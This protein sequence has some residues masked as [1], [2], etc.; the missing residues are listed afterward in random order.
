MN[1]LILKCSCCGS[2]FTRNYFYGGFIDH[3]NVVN[4]TDAHI[5]RWD[6]DDQYRRKMF[7]EALGIDGNLCDIKDA[8]VK[9][10]TEKFNCTIKYLDSCGRSDISSYL[11]ENRSM[12]NLEFIKIRK[13]LINESKIEIKRLNKI[14]E[15]HNVE[16]EKLLSYSEADNN[17]PDHHNQLMANDEFNK[18]IAPKQS[19][20]YNPKTKITTKTPVF[21]DFKESK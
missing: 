3:S 15:L 17:N 2:E 13:S 20:S 8:T 9:V 5:I 14:N 16:I 7:L 10:A 1:N 21:S 12:I 11:N 19:E 6:K 4:N 18:L